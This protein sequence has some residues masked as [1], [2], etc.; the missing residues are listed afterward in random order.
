MNHRGI[1]PA[2]L[3]FRNPEDDAHASSQIPRTAHTSHDKLEMWDT[4]QQ[5]RD[6]GVPY[7][8]EWTDV[9]GYKPVSAYPPL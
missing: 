3:L 1:T 2:Y 5:K 9:L 7:L 4:A 8:K 6:C